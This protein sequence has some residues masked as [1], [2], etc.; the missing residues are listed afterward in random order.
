MLKVVIC[1]WDSRGP[2]GAGYALL[3]QPGDVRG[4]GEN[5]VK[6]L[7]YICMYINI[8]VTNVLR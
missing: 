5:R 1:L 6:H 2:D 4:K 8:F 3:H 7:I